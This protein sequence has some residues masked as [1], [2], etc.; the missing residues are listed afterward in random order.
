VT[1]RETTVRGGSRILAF[2][3]AVSL[4]TVFDQA[5]KAAVKEL[6]EVEGAS[7]PFIPNIMEL[8]L[9]FNTGAAFSIGQ[10]AGII[11]IILAIAVLAMMTVFIWR[12]PEMPL[13]LAIAMGCV[14]GGGMG[15]MIDRIIFGAV[16]DF[17]CTTFI[18]FAIFNVADIFVTCGLVVTFLLFLYYDRKHPEEKD[19]R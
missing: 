2:W 4:V 8:R 3:V 15:N 7:C 9:V 17:L 11:F 19:E 5:T 10:G 12:N 18:D 1:G 14:A 6:L 16:T 13:S